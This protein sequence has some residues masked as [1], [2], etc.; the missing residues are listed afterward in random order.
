M[1]KWPLPKGW[2]W[3]KIEEVCKVNPRR[4]SLERD[5]ETPTSFVPM[6]AVDENKGAITDMEVH[7]YQE[8][9]RGYT[10]FEEEDVLFAKITPSMEN[11]KAA[12]ARGLIDGI[13]FG[14][15][16][17]HRLRPGDHIIPEWAYFFVRQS[18]F[19]REAAAHFRGSVG[20]QRVPKEF[21]AQHLIPVPPLETQR[22]L[23]ARIEELLAELG[24]AR[25]LHAALVHDAERLMDAAL[26]ETFSKLAD[27]YGLELLGE[28]KPFITSGPRYW[29]KYAEERPTG[30][31]FLRIGNIGYAQLD[32][33]D[34]E[35][36]ELPEDLAR[37]RARVQANDVLVTITGTIGRCAV[38]PEHL[39]EAYINQHTALVRLNQETILPRYLMWFVL[40]P[41][42]NGQAESAAYGQTKPGLNLTQLRELK[43]PVPQ[44]D[45]QHRIVAY[46]NEVQAHAAALQH[47]AAA[48]AADL[49]RLEQSILAQAFKGKL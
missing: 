2:E 47:A 48:I 41:L 5:E 45:Q 10:Y 44:T 26:L 14:S 21:L 6:A 20:Q 29:S 12:I 7:P 25:H 37:K 30:P 36:L 22:R 19:R 4:P 24:A 31:L 28:Y 43:L 32:L 11:G 18:S 33:D 9:M 3:H 42:G 23:V 27:Q 35:R 15:T 13:G 39:Q 8:V 38:V 1:E 17:F 34:I 49:D 40:S 46:L 16:E